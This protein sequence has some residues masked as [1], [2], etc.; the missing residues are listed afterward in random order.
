MSN[1]RHGVGRFRW[2][3]LAIASLMTGCLSGRSTIP[4]SIP[5][6]MLPPSAIIPNSVPPANQNP[7]VQ[8][9]VI[10]P[11][12]A[13]VAA[14]S[15]TVQ[16]GGAIPREL[17]M[18]TT[19]EYRV[20][21][22]DIVRIDVLRVIP[23]VP[24]KIEPLD[25]LLIQVNN[26]PMIP[27]PNPTPQNP[28][29]QIEESI[30]GFFLVEP[31]GTINL[32][33]RYGTIVKVAGLS[34][35]EAKEAVEK[36]LKTNGVKNPF[37]VVSLGQS[38]TLQQVRGE[39]LVQ[40]DGTVNLG[41]YGSVRVVGMTVKE[42]RQAIESHLAQF[43]QS[44]EASVQVA[45]YNS[46]TYYVIFD[47]AGRGQQVIRLPITGRE[48]VLDAISQVNGLTPVSSKHRIFIA[49]PTPAQSGK[50]VIL[51]VDWEGVSTCARTDTNYQIMAGDRL[52]VHSDG[53]IAIDNALAK[54]V[55]PFER[56][57]GF[58]LLGN[59]TVR[60]LSGSQNSTG[61]SGF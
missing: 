24:Y 58:T 60:A 44:P 33:S 3:G 26:L 39:H 47:G 48:T 2:F 8:T 38:R 40:Q 28:A 56:L 9:Q 61:G 23:K 16:T 13:P 53:W 25:G 1:H 11:T 15:M 29:T 57:F 45:A 6:T 50:Q 34:L 7:I 51:P 14:T 4:G 36:Y 20:E 59:G 30:N 19:P 18:V 22:P 27:N 42:T 21:P 49:R 41:F 55:S 5:T 37:V 32:A 46:K 10:P 54:F 17:D 31:D 43:L 12:G 52:Y 35:I